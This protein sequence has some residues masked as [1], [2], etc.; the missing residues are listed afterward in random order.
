[1]G[2]HGNVFFSLI[3]ADENHEFEYEVLFNGIEEV[4]TEYIKKCN[5]LGIPWNFIKKEPGL[6]FHYFNKFYK[7]I[8]NS[9]AEIIFLHSS[10]Y[11][12]PAVIANVSSRK[13]KKIIVTETEAYNLKSNKEWLWLS[14]AFLMADKIVFLSEAYKIAVEKKFRWLYNTKK[15]VVIPNGINVNK[16]HAGFQPSNTLTIGMQSRL[17]PN[18]DHITLLRSFSILIKQGYKIKLKIA[19]DGTCKTELILLS[20]KLN[21]ATDVEF[22]GVLEEDDLVKFLQQLNLYIHASFGE[23]MS[24]AIMQAMACG[25]P[26]IASDVPG[27]N[28]MI[29]N[30]ETGILVPVQKEE[31]LADAIKH[32]LNNTKVAD[33][34][35]ERASEY[36]NS[37]YSHYTM[38]KK[39]KEIFTR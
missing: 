7:T 20:Q 10:V 1:L 28:N 32:L 23:T 2:G 11:I 38:Y 31:L 33:E 3:T 24:T 27:I 34:L 21:I 6:D 8:K 25:L 22:L 36:A 9:T 12:L 14:T 19:G 26:I 39:Y 35:G 4:R 37:K 18:K 5:V 17:A 29:I 15:V 30:G 16:F 13:K